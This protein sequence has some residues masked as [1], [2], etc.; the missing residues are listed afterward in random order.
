MKPLQFAAQFA[1]FAWYTNNRMAPDA[2][3]QE[4]ARRFAIENWEKFLP[5]ANEGLGRLL[6]R[7]AKTPATRQHRVA[8]P[9]RRSTKRTLAVAG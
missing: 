3:I 2:I 4:E 1:A 7:I 9:M 8:P 5:V 6:L